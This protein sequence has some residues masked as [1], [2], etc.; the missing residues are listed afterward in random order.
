MEKDINPPP[1]PPPPPTGKR[2]HMQLDTNEHPKI[3][4]AT[5]KKHSKLGHG[6]EVGELNIPGYSHG[7]VDM[8]ASTGVSVSAGSSQ[9]TEDSSEEDQADTTVQD[10]ILK[11]LHCVSTPVLTLSKTRWPHHLLSTAQIV[12]QTQS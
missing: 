8:N 11:E 12:T 10:M 2:C 5:T 6:S 9:R 4:K 3:S 1:P 7:S